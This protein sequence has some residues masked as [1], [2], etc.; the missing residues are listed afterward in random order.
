MIGYLSGEV[1]EIFEN[2]ILL[3][4]NGVGYKIYPTKNCLEGS[5]K[6]K[7]ASYYITS[8]I[9]E[10]LFDLYGFE[11]MEDKNLF[12]L[13]INISGIGPRTA[14]A[15][16]SKFKVKDIVT[17]VTSG[18]AEFFSGIPRLGKKN[19]QKLIIELKTKLGDLTPMSLVESQEKME[20][21]DALKSLGYQEHEI[22]PRL[23][24]I[25]SMGDT[26]ELKIKYALK[27]L[28]KK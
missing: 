13:M 4:V 24:E 1:F 28:G 20:I 16:L 6:G 14:I 2:Y 7:K 5:Q 18:N 10:D 9:K 21:I 11:S 17:A 22:M 15:I 27:N 25:S 19:A 8:I 12:D 26:L 3:L 23:G